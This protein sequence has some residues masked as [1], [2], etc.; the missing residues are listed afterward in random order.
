MSHELHFGSY[1][2]TFMNASMHA[3]ARTRQSR[4]LGGQR[5]EAWEP[6]VRWRSLWFDELMHTLTKLPADQQSE[7]EPSPLS[8]KGQRGKCKA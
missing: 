4:K 3:T 1:M 8:R 7:G 5:D 6:R 2:D